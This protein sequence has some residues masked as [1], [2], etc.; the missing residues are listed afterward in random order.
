MDNES[1]TNV[2]LDS[3]F[4]PLLWI[5]VCNGVL[6]FHMVKESTLTGFAGDMPMVVIT[7]NA[8]NGQHYGSKTIHVIKSWLRKA[9]LD[10]TNEKVKVISMTNPKKIIWSVVT[11]SNRTISKSTMRYPPRE[12]IMIHNK[13][14]FKGNVLIML[15][16]SSAYVKN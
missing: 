15:I 6:R 9:K 3:E 11:C 2:R 4:R 16:K 7:R 8:A 13:L 12:Q 5:I 14:N 1:R 10:L